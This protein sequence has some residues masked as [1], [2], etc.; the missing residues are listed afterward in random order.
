LFWKSAILIIYKPRKQHIGDIN[1]PCRTPRAYSTGMFFTFSEFQRIFD[2]NTNFLQFEGIIRSIKKIFSQPGL[3]NKDY[4]IQN[5][6]MQT[7]LNILTKDRKGSRSIYM[8]GVMVI[9]Q[10]N[11][12]LNWSGKT[13]SLMSILIGKRCTL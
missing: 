7:S 3:T 13:T 9:T 10:L 11:Q 5:P 2:V 8:Y 1:N 6:L 4:K 12:N